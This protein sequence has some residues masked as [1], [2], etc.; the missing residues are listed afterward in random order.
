MSVND[1]PASGS[2]SA[3]QAHNPRRVPSDECRAWRAAVRRGGDVKA[4]INT[5][6]FHHATVR[7]HLRGACECRHGVPELTFQDGE[8]LPVESLGTLVDNPEPA[9]DVPPRPSRLS[10]QQSRRLDSLA[11]LVVQLP[12]PGNAYQRT[13][14]SPELQDNYDILREHGF[15]V[16]LDEWADLGARW[17][18]TDAAGYKAARERFKQHESEGA[19]LS[20]GHRGMTNP[21]DVDGYGCRHYG[22]YCD[23][24]HTREEIEEV[25]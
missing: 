23:A 25:L 10:D 16:P 6:T 7:A 22:D 20:C 17:V 4:V 14:L 13:N 3:A 12:A 24:V 19:L 21:R 9:P 1:A 11:W 18:H 15:I 2:E 5:T 8:W